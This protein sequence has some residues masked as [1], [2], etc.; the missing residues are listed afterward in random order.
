MEKKDTIQYVPTEPIA[1]GDTLLEV[2]EERGM[3]QQEFA[4]RLGRPL[5]T[6]NG[7]VKGKNAITPETALQFEQ[8]L[9]IPARF[10]NN[11]E[12]QYQELKLRIES[13]KQNKALIPES[14]NYPY[15]E[16]SK[17]GWIPVTR[18]SSK[19][20]DNLLRYF[21]VTN[22][23]NIVEEIKLQGAFRIS[24]KHRYSMP[25][26]VS[27]VRKGTIDAE[28][29]QTESFDERKLKELIPILRK[30]THVD[31]PN[32]LLQQLREEFAKCGIAF[33]VTQSLT[34]APISGLTRW[35]SPDK[36]LIQMSLRWAWTD[37]FWFTLFH[38]VGHVLLDNKKDFNIDLIS[39][40]I[41]GDRESEK[42]KFAADT[43]IPQQEYEKLVAKIHSNGNLAGI[44]D[45]V[46]SFAKYVDIHP[47]IV[48]GRLQHD[49]LMPPNMNGLRIR[50]MW[51]KP[52]IKQEE[53]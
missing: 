4:T 9:G 12:S 49:K 7:I 2:L 32:T 18:D 1:P 24:D 39:R 33:V 13:E 20:V 53:L 47:G 34:N 52:Q 5:K 42:D 6:V 40:K 19:R 16:M 23:E 22:F 41:D 43:L 37:I 45:L 29:I 38:E 3:T 27:W 11:L 21:G 15:L 26:I 14:K 44:Y 46:R 35:I 10:W 30:M 25:A 50:F 28:S 48:V 31:D 8:V 51:K 17:W 36:A